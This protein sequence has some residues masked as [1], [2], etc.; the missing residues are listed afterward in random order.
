MTRIAILILIIAAEHYLAVT[1]L[2]HQPWHYLNYSE[3]ALPL[4]I[5]VARNKC[6]ISP[7]IIQF[8]GL[9]WFVQYTPSLQPRSTFHAT[10]AKRYH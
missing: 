7:S 5:I 4:T 3:R 9:S 8:S 2:L 10:R 6:S 1:N